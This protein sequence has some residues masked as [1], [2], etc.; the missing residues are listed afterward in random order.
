MKNILLFDK[1]NNYWNTIGYHAKLAG[2]LFIITSVSLSIIFISRYHLLKNVFH[3]RTVNRLNTLGKVLSEEI[4][5]NIVDNDIPNIRETIAITLESKEILFIIYANSDNTVIVASDPHLENIQNSK[6]DT[7]SIKYKKGGVFIRSFPLLFKNKS[8]GYVQIGFSVEKLRNAIHYLLRWA[9]LL[10]LI[11]I[12]FTA[13]AAY[14]FSNVFLAPL[15]KIRE[16][17]YLIAHGDFTH[18]LDIKSHDIIGD[19]SYALNDMA[20]KLAGL[21]DKLHQKISAATADLEA[22]NIELQNKTNHLVEANERLIKMDR[23]KSEFVSIVSHELRTPLTNIIGFAKTL[24]TIELPENNKMRFLGIIESEG[25][26]LSS[27]IEEFLDI[28]KIE[29]GNFEIYPALVNIQELMGEIIELFQN[30]DGNVIDCRLPDSPVVASIDRNRIKQ[31]LLNIIDNAIKYSEPKSIVHVDVKEEQNE[32]CI[33]FRDHG[34]GIH[35]DDL[36]KLFQKFYR[37]RN[38]QTMRTRGSGLGLAIVEGIIKAHRG[39]IW[40]E[41]I[42]GQGSTFFIA[43]PK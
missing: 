33:S 10:N 39:R 20:D 1:I 24:M 4:K 3:E 12:V 21:T 26:R 18:R 34:P 13:G 37:C 40:V 2:T 29:T 14:F 30:K 36:Q 43:I 38:S 27:L 19:L 7:P 25:K 17:T 9:F 32:I 35:P 5:D 41:S 28:S 42:V 22:A 16:V 11:A 15:K 23:L 8:L 6:K 31:V